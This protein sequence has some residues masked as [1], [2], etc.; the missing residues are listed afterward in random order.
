M[1]CESLYSIPPLHSVK[2]SYLK[3][4]IDF[5]Y[6]SFNDLEYLKYLLDYISTVKEFPNPDEKIRALSCQVQYLVFCSL[7]EIRWR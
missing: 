1:V 4:E 6:F 2:W 3:C 5:N 7:K